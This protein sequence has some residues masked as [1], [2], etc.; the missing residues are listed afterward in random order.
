[1]GVQCQWEKLASLER[2]DQARTNEGQ[3]EGLG[4]DLVPWHLSWPLLQKDSGLGN[5]DCH[6]AVQMVPEL[7]GHREA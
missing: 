2:V 5:S 6:H 3:A 4:C 1:M 7:Q